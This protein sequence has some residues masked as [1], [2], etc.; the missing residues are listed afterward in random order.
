MQFVRDIKYYIGDVNLAKCLFAAS[1]GIMFQELKGKETR[2]N[3]FLANE[4]SISLTLNLFYEYIYKQYL[5]S[6]IFGTFMNKNKN[7][8]KAIVTYKCKKI[9]SKKSNIIIKI[10]NKI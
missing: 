5:Y 2:L 9:Y 8:I 6:I 4:L 10:Q 1:D 3:I 7:I